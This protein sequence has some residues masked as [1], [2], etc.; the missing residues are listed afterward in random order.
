[1]S[2]QRRGKPRL[3][4][5]FSPD[6]REL[7]GPRLLITPEYPMLAQ[8]RGCGN[9]P[10]DM[11][12]ITAR[13]L[14]VLALVGTF[15]PVAMAIA[16]PAMHEC[17]LRAGHG[18][19]PHCRKAHHSLAVEAVHHGCCDPCCSPNVPVQWAQL[20]RPRHAETAFVAASLSAQSVS[21][22]RSAELYA[23]LPARAPPAC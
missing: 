4:R 16:G 17:C 6:A 5:L 19:C 22:H 8:S 15:T 11:Q 2:M 12:R 20:S 10:A 14:L 9:F 18:S 3:C 21:L 1:M 7:R 13:L 23:V